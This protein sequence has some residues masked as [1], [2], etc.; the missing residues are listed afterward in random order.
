M[1]A[2][3]RC[4]YCYELT[5][6]VLVKFGWVLIDLLDDGSGVFTSGL[7]CGDPCAEMSSSRAGTVRG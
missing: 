5:P 7:Y 2:F 3:Y 1:S 6:L 4:D